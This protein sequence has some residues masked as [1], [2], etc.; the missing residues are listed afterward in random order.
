[1][2]PPS[3]DDA[4]GFATTVTTLI[5]GVFNSHSFH[6]RQLSEVEQNCFP[7]RVQA[8]DLKLENKIVALKGQY[9]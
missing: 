2:V 3:E 6:K 7:T 5:G 4:D 9:F 8:K 1:M